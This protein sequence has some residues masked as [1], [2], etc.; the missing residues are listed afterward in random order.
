VATLNALIA[1]DG[2]SSIIERKFE[3][4]TTSSCSDGETNAV[5]VSGNSFSYRLSGLQPDTL[6]YFR[7]SARNSAGWSSISSTLHFRTATPAAQQQPQQ[8]SRNYPDPKWTGNFADDTDQMI[9]ARAIF[10]E[11]R[12]EEKDGKI[13]VGWVIKNR[14]DNPRWWG[15]TYHEVILKYDERSSIHQFTCFDEND[16]KNEPNLK[17]VRDPLNDKNSDTVKNNWYESYDVAGGIL[18]NHVDDPTDN[19]DHYYNPD[20]SDPIWDDHKAPRIKIGNHLFIRL[21]L[22]PKTKNLVKEITPKSTEKDLQAASTINFYTNPST[23]GSI[24]FSDTA[25]TNGQ[26]GKY[27]FGT[28]S[29]STNI[30]SGYTFKSWSTSGSI[31][32]ASLNSFSTIATINGDGS[33]TAN[34]EQTITIYQETTIQE[35]AVVYAKQAINAPYLFGGKGYNWSDRRYV[36]PFELKEGYIYKNWDPKTPQ[37]GKGIDCSGLIFWSYNKA[38]NKNK[39]I[40]SSNPINEDGAA[41]QWY[42]VL[43]PQQKHTNIPTVS[44]LK[45]GDLLFILINKKPP[46]ITEPHVAIYIGNGEVIHSQGGVGVKKITLKEWLDLPLTATERYSDYFTGYG[47]IKSASVELT[48]NDL[49]DKSTSQEQEKTP[50]MNIQ[51]AN[52]LSTP[53]NVPK[54]SSSQTEQATQQESK[55]PGSSTVVEQKKTPAT[56]IQLANSLSTPLTVSNTVNQQTAV[57]NIPS[58]FT[59][60]NPLFTNKFLT[61][62][63]A[64][65][66]VKEPPTTDSEEREIV[67]SEQIMRSV[68]EKVESTSKPDAIIKA[69]EQTKNIKTPRTSEYTIPSQVLSPVLGPLDYTTCCDE[70]CQNR[71]IDKWEFCQHKSETLVKSSSGEWL[72]IGHI[73]NGGIGQA[74]DTYAWDVNYNLQKKKDED[75]GKPVYAVASG[76]VAKT[77]GDRLNIG[78]TYGQVLLEHPGGWWSGY[79]HMKDIRVTEGQDV[80]D[81][82]LLGYIS[83]TG[84]SANH[85]HFVV[86]RGENI[87]GGLKSFDIEITPR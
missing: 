66:V 63:L 61:A 12:G 41:G 34:L 35:R 27:S 68:S 67:S 22:E 79:L 76:K 31:S 2:G 14:V 71:I 23:V 15:R 83:N 50:A 73:P 64:G 26:S 84:T 30:P 58:L 82:T 4:G 60:D 36:D 5:S 32:V 74:D 70:N 54:T 10:G 78:G 6:Y 69:E 1:S 59:S 81:Q 47:S 18:N 87:E 43:D 37:S 86:Y 65:T 38:A 53:V 80:N 40:D 56:N 52:S 57:K 45:I 13:A 7:A 17:L 48:S 11:A 85:L 44:D 16:P 51:L 21:Y 29:I 28:Y 3:W 20:T 72:S 9:L 39:Y 55:T 19:A 46:G 49:I 24:T 25:Y 77:Y 62:N 42:N 8:V 75:A 33:L